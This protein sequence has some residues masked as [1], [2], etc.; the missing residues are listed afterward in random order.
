MAA[1]LQ[2]LLFKKTQTENWNIRN[3]FQQFCIVMLFD[4]LY[5]EIA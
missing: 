2:F 5:L 1:I 4:Y 3:K